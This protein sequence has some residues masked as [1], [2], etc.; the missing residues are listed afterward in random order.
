MNQP[1]TIKVWDPLL[2]FFHWALVLL[3]I[4][5]FATGEDESII[6]IWSGYGVAGLIVFRLLWGLIGPKYARFS[7]FIYSPQ[8]ILVYGRGLFDGSAKRYLGHNPLGG[9]MVVALL[10]SLSMASL[11]GMMLYGAEE[12]KGPLA[13]VMQA[14]NKIVLPQLISTAQ[15]DDD[16]DHEYRGGESE[17]LEESHEFFAN[18]SILLIVFHLVGVLFESL[19]HRESLIRSMF[20]GYKRTDLR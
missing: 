10:L 4:I 3:F 14:E 19:F 11:T 12:A 5:S 17:V 13:S 20:N 1:D 7:N 15:A 8:D 18:L 6:H 9:L 16:E 2:R